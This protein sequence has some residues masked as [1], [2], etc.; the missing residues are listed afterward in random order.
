MMSYD[1][2]VTFYYS[3]VDSIVDIY[4]FIEK[5]QVQSSGL[6]PALLACK[7]TEPRQTTSLLT[8]NAISSWHF[9]YSRDQN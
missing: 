4:K 3:A 9:T 2:Y 8:S 7:A 6:E 5:R 1:A